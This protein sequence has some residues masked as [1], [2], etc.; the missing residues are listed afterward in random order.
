M[1]CHALTAS[2][3]SDVPLS[4]RASCTVGL[5]MENGA[6]LAAAVLGDCT[7]VIRTTDDDHIVVSDR[8]LDRFDSAVAREIAG[9]MAQGVSEQD[10]RAAV[11]PKLIEN[12]DR[13]NSNQTYW[14]FADDPAAA[15]QVATQSVEIDRVEQVLLCSD[16]FWRLVDPFRAADEQAEK[17]DST[18]SEPRPCSFGQRLRD[19]S[20]RIAVWSNFPDSRSQTTQPRFSSRVM[21]L[22]SGGWAEVA[23]GLT[24]AQDLERFASLL[25]PCGGGQWLSGMA[26]V[27]T[28][29]ML[30]RLSGACFAM[31][32]SR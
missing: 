21:H 30:L 17:L 22:D 6:D 19:E 23:C 27:A 32:L 12:R 13:G 24:V 7:V 2:R 8:R 9:R 16:G 4:R 10:A 1:F 11:T 18:S 14:L 25:S 5:V 31:R 20:N 26:S 28:S 29:P 3:G 15:G